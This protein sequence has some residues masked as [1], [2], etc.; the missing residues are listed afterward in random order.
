MKKL[1]LNTDNILTL[2][3]S[4]A[5]VETYKVR[6]SLVGEDGTLLK[7]NNDQD[8]I[9]LSTGTEPKITFD[10]TLSKFKATIHLADDTAK[11]Y[12]RAFWIVTN[13]NDIPVEISGY[14]PEEISVENSPT[15]STQVFDP[16]IVPAQ[17]FIDSFL[18]A[19]PSISEELVNAIAA[20]NEKNPDI[21]KNELLASQDLLEGDIRTKFF[22]TQFNLDRDWNDEIFYANYWFQQVDWL[23]LVSVDSYKLIYGNQNI[24]LSNDLAS[25]MKVDKTQG[26]IE[27]LPTIVSG[28]LFTIIISTVSALA[29]SMV[30]MGERSRIP[31]LFRIVYT[32]GMDFPNLPVQKKERIRRLISRHCFCQIMPRIDQ[33]IRETSLSQSI[34]GASLS[35]SSGVPDIIKQFKEDELRDIALFQKE[36]GTNIAIA[37][38]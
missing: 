38:S 29:I 30:A 24:E 33:L 23:P 13:E 34:D 21:I 7:D 15:D 16:L 6:L 37:V 3:S 18:G 4:S 9:L 8:L 36:L 1:Y 12:V 11:Q 25:S 17:Y 5:Q 32:A 19:D 26:T 10:S 20:I 2:D 27:W 14:Y 22:K 35:R 28:N 31:G